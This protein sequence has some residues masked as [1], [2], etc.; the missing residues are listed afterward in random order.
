MT[1]GQ[2]T[3]CHSAADKHTALQFCRGDYQRGIIEGTHNLSATTATSRYRAAYR[4]S[5]AQ[6]IIR[7]RQ[8]GLVVSEARGARGARILVIGQPAPVGA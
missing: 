7:L 1:I 6:L 4:R 3:I 8:A 2:W 5:A